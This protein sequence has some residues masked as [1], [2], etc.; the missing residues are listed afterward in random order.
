MANGREL[1]SN[2]QAGRTVYTYYDNT[3]DELYTA[4]DGGQIWK[5]NIGSE[6][7]HSIN[8]HIKISAIRYMTKFYEASFTRLLVH[9]GGWNK[10]GIM[11]SD[12]DGE[13]WELASGLDN[14]VSWGFI[15]RA[16]VQTNTQHSIYIVAQEWDYSAWK[17]SVAFISL[18]I[19]V[20][21][22]A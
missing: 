12:D 4:A 18:P 1:G 14:I 20:N 13:S 9:S 7:W 2:N 17:A 6:N 21:H 11:Y 10:V 15:K 5:G 22:S 19:W 16:V 8:D 3:T